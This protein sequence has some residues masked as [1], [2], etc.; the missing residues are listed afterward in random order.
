MKTA[1]GRPKILKNLD[2]MRLLRTRNGY[3]GFFPIPS[4]YINTSYMV[5]YIL[6]SLYCY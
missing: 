1:C 6:F 3:G 2:S 4:I 5:L